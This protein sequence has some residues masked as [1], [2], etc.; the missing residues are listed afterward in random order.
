MSIALTP[1]YQAIIKLCNASNNDVLYQCRFSNESQTREFIAK[2]AKSRGGYSLLS[3][4]VFPLRTDTF[5]NYSEDLFLPTFIHYSSKINNFV[6]KF[7]ASIFAVA[8]DI[9]TV[10]IRIMTTPLQLYYN[11]GPEEKHPILNL[12]RNTP[13][14]QKAIEGNAVDLCYEVQNVQ[15]S[16]PT[17]EDGNTFQ[18]AKKSV[19]K[20]TIQVAL[21]KLPG[22]IKSQSE[23]EKENTSYLGMNGD[24]VIENFDT[25]KTSISSFAC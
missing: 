25:S 9:V 7:L 20:G 12:M 21:K 17:Y 23:E 4:L 18:N 10:P 13:Q 22:G 6:L 24:W 2:Y 19:I 3:S 11:N 15:I 1:G 14:V 8:F 5:K 16:N